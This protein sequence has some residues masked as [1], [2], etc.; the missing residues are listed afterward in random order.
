MNAQ[1]LEACIHKDNIIEAIE[2]VKLIG[3]TKDETCLDILLKYLETTD[4]HI[5]RNKIALALSD[6]GNNKATNGLI[7]VL[8]HPK[9][10]G[11]RG[12]L[13]YALKELD[14]V[15]HISIITNLI[16]DPTLEISMEAYLLLE[17]VTDSLSNEQKENCKIILESKLNNKENEYIRAALDLLQ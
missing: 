5:L 12:T 13:L 16:G 1:K 8:L 2:L 14:Y 10:K 11:S 6:I 17:H 3:E 15:H 4:N 9:T 7:E